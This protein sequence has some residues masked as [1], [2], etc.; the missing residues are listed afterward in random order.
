MDKN[1]ENESQYSYYD[2]QFA[3]ICNT[4]KIKQQK[5]KRI[6]GFN[7]RFENNN[8]F[9]IK[10]NNNN[11]SNAIDKYGGTFLDGIFK[12]II[13]NDDEIIS[14]L[15]Y[16]LMEEEFDS[17][18]VENDVE[19]NNG[20]QSNINQYLNDKNVYYGIKRSINYCKNENMKHGN[21]FSIGY[22][23]YYWDYYKKDDIN[24]LMENDSVNEGGHNINN[25]NGYKISEL[26]VIKKYK[27]IKTEILQN[28]I[29]T[30]HIFEWKTT[31]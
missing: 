18:A 1:Y 21:M 29:Y 3:N 2:E 22:R 7:N 14:K 25:H 17:D 24:K 11:N 27:N 13:S 4:I 9:N 31:A 23:F 16:M 30:L 10:I 5:L 19:Y 8:K 26:F 28:K 20:K 6:N 15:K 12:H